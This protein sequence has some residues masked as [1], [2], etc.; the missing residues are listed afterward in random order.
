MSLRSR[1]HTAQHRIEGQ[2]PQQIRLWSTLGILAGLTL[3][4]AAMILFPR[5]SIMQWWL[6]APGSLMVLAGVAGHLAAIEME[7][8]AED[9][10][11]EDA[12]S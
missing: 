3:V 8:I 11:G 6:V 4:A 9:E 1:L 7:Q 10:T 2:A 12:W 5:T